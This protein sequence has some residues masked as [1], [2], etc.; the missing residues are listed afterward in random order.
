MG[1]EFA[2]ERHVPGPATFQ[3]HQDMGTTRFFFKSL[4]CLA[5]WS[6]GGVAGGPGKSPSRKRDSKV[7]TSRAFSTKP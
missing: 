4:L 7:G 5:K 1:S 6:E 2:S 3:P